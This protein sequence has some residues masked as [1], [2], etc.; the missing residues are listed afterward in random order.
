MSFAVA[1][2]PEAYEALVALI[3]DVAELVVDE[4][5]RLAVSPTMAGG[6]SL[7]DVEP[8]LTFSSTREFAGRT[9]QIE[10][11]FQYGQDEE[12]LH[13]LNIAVSPI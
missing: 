12:T 1:L 4:I 13:I 6:I 5:D 2:E 7:P 10:I 9:Y 11:T 3:P 8:G